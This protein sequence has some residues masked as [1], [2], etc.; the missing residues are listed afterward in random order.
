[1]TDWKEN[2]RE[3]FEPG[4]EVVAYRTAEEYLEQVVYYLEHDREREAIARCGRKRTLREH[5][6]FHRMRE[7]PQTLEKGCGA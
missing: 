1:M 5:T 4:V 2:L 6:V 3:I 7:M